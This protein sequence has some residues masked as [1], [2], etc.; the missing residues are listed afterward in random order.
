MTRDIDIAVVQTF[1]VFFVGW[2]ARALHYIEEAE[3]DRWSRLVIDFLFPL[4]VFH[5]L[6]RGLNV[7]RFHA[8]VPLPVSASIVTRRYGGSPDFAAR[9]AVLTTLASIVT[10]PAALLLLEK[11]ISGGSGARVAAP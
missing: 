11:F 8:L 2:L 1:G 3:I 10:I 9:A 5:S 7:E 6:A 4:L